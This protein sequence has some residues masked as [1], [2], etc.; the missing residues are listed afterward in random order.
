MRR[1]LLLILLFAQTVL[2]DGPY[3]TFAGV[4]AAADDAL[5]A[6][7]NPAAMTLFDGRQGRFELLGF[8]SE[9]TWEGQLGE[10]G[11]ATT[12]DSDSSTLVPVGA[13]ITPFRD[14]W[15]FGFTIVGS[16]FSEEFDDDW[17]GRYL[18]QDYE[19]VYISAFPS[20][21][22]RLNERWSVAASLALTYTTYEQRK[23]VP[24]VE[25]GIGDGSLFLETDGLSVGYGLSALYEWTDRTRLGLTYRSEIEPSLKGKAKFSDLGPITEEILDQAGLL[26][27]KVDVTSRQPRSATIGLSHDRSNGHSVTL[28]GAWIN[29]SRFKVA[30]V[31]V[32]GEQLVEN[33]QDYDDAIAFSA[34]YSWPINDRTRLGLGGLVVSDFVGRSNRTMAFR[35]DDLWSVGIGVKWQWREDRAVNVSLNYLTVGDAPVESPELPGLGPVT[36]RYTS[37]DTV[38]LRAA[39]SFGGGA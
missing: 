18:L 3:P 21:A 32:E 35:L 15:W 13:M 19:L 9:S 28:D 36:G 25:P 33:L 12:M 4:S 14:N 11:P 16:G 27:A 17:A 5:V 20:I 39:I 2:A 31:Y 34:S 37:R 10:D 30:E 29:F 26:G 1:C 7:T 24:N 8:A 6:G 23:A 38:Y 22:T